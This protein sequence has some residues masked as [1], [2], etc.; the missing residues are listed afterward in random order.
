MIFGVYSPLLPVRPSCLGS[1]GLR[2][3]YGSSLRNPVVT[4]SIFGQ[5]C[6]FLCFLFSFCRPSASV[7]DTGCGCG[8]V[9]FSLSVARWPVCFMRPCLR[10]CPPTSSTS[11]CRHRAPS[12]DRIRQQRLPLS[13]WFFFLP[14]T[15]PGLVPSGGLFEMLNESFFLLCALDLPFI[16]RRRGTP[17]PDMAT[18]VVLSKVCGTGTL[19]VCAF[20]R[21]P[22][23]TSGRLTRVFLSGSAQPFWFP[24]FLACRPLRWGVPKG[25]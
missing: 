16:P 19:A 18:S 24:L 20:W 25:F 13:F 7:A 22:F 15:F 23:P 2:P 3:P 9:I 10:L 8:L 5:V 11:G 4:A 17:P 14:R 12:S 1:P 21:G 6:L